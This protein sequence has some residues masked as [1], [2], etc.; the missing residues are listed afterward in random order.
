MALLKQGMKPAEVAREVGVS[1]ISV[2]RWRQA[3]EAEGE[4]GLTAKA[5]PGRTPKLTESQRKRL[6]KLLS[7][8]ARKHGYGT[9][10]WTGPR[11]VE[12][13]EVNFGVQYESGQA[14]RLLRAVGWKDPE[15]GS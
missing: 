5:P 6:A 10:R 12:L 13:I 2:T 11:V 9:D 1:R 8:G 15:K 4:T 14:R 3:Y 7:Q